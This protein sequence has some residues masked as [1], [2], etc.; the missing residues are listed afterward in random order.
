MAAI[1]KPEF[2]QACHAV[3][4]DLSDEEFAK[5]FP[6]T[7]VAMIEMTKSNPFRLNRGKNGIT[8]EDIL[9]QVERYNKELDK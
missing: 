7:K 5:L 4:G 8:M 6:F 9:K 2:D 1:I 3:I